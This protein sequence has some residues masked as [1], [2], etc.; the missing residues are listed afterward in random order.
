MK[1]FLNKEFWKYLS[2]IFLIF[3]FIIFI[4]KYNFL[5]E[6]FQNL[7]NKISYNHFSI[8][9]DMDG[10]EKRVL[11]SPGLSSNEQDSFIIHMGYLGDFLSGTLGIFFSFLSIIFVIISLIRQNR[12]NE[13]NEIEARIFRFIEM[14][15]QITNQNDLLK[16]AKKFVEENKDNSDVEELKRIMGRDYRVFNNYFN[17]LFNLLKYIYDR[18]ININSYYKLNKMASHEVIDYTNIISANISS[19]L[20]Y[21]LAINCYVLPEGKKKDYLFKFFVERYSFFS[22]LPNI[23][24]DYINKSFNLFIYYDSN[25]FGDNHYFGNLKVAKEL[26]EI[27]RINKL[28]NF[29]FIFFEFLAKKGGGWSNE[30]LN[31]NVTKDGDSF[32]ITL[33]FKNDLN[34]L[35]KNQLVFKLGYDEDELFNII[36]DDFHSDCKLFS[37]T[38]SI[39]MNFS[40]DYTPKSYEGV[41]GWYTS[42]E[43]K[44]QLLDSF[45]IEVDMTDKQINIFS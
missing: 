35:G 34:F 26:A 19:D 17:V 22:D 12:K 28:N 11:L 25:A 38:N 10:N 44:I 20:L 33:K 39:I 31:L 5:G 32:K 24:E 21:C 6:D 29:G 27:S 43:I 3:A 42:A 45:K 13:L 18:E 7:A 41:P 4:Y 16:V 14:L 37:N 30:S 1:Y 23:D 9:T 2:I 8:V 36:E 15:S 40:P